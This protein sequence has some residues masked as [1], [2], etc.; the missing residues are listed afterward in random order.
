MGWTRAVVQGPW[1][2]RARWRLY[3]P[4]VAMAVAAAVVL[5]LVLRGSGSGR[6]VLVDESAPSE[7]ASP[8]PTDPAAPTAT[9]PAANDDPG[10]APAPTSSSSRVPPSPQPSASPE[11][12]M[13]A[14]ASALL[15]TGYLER[16]F[17]QGRAARVVDLPAAVPVAYSCF[18]Q[19]TPTWRDG[20]AR[21]TARL[22]RVWSWAGEVTVTEILAEFP[23]TA[24]ARQ[25]A[26]ECVG[27]PDPDLVGTW[28][29]RGTSVKE[30]P[31][32]GEL[33]FLQ[34]VP[35]EVM[36]TAYSG[37]LQGRVV[38]LLNWRQSGHDA[39][40]DP[41]RRALVSAFDKARGEDEG[42]P[43]A[44]APVIPLR[45]LQG[46]LTIGELPPAV[47]DATGLRWSEDT[48]APDKGI[49]CGSDVLVRTQD[50]P[51]Q[52]G[53]VAAAPQKGAS[54]SFG[55]SPSVAEA[56]EDF[57]ACRTSLADYAPAAV[58]GIGD[59]A[60]LVRFYDVSFLYLRAGDVVG[61]VA[62]DGDESASGLARTA[63]DHYLA[64]R[65]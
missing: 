55:V 38:L 60:F 14:T 7:S 10:G 44:A 33:G 52:R 49:R 17:G 54:F 27:D 20:V 63:L 11:P 42:T 32:V 43:I 58:D 2:L 15:S 59:E 18:D 19:F 16:A 5:V 65:V 3:L 8:A 37:T 24:D 25:F 41:L 26:Q 53:Y 1:G 28:D 30:Q 34:R 6:E 22:T 47:G 12:R 35:R 9:P 40:L 57:A 39:P 29:P 62:A 50:V 51:W 21:P 23:T 56:T 13:S 31:D 64:A 48:G 46:Y 4:F 45:E 36:T 61:M